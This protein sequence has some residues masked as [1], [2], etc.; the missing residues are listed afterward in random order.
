[1]VQ[2]VTGMMVCFNWNV[3]WTYRCE[4]IHD[5]LDIIK[6]KTTRNT[7]GDTLLPRTFIPN[8]LP[9]FL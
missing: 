9:L 8:N 1:M 6:I 7:L 3:M 2:D 4:N 5:A